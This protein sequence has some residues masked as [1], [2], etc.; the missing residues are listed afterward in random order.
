MASV[1]DEIE[2]GNT[3]VQQD[4]PEGSGY[5]IEP[6]TSNEQTQDL[7]TAQPVSTPAASQFALET[8]EPTSTAEST[9]T[10]SSI[11]TPNSTTTTQQ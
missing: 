10:P 7:S 11:P 4:I 6:I 8:A 1:I 9:P 3:V 5:Y 2:A